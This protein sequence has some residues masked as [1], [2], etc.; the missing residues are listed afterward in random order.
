M[1]IGGGRAVAAHACRQL[2]A[3]PE[4]KGSAAASGVG[5]GPC[6]AG[7]LGREGCIILWSTSPHPAGPAVLQATCPHGVPTL[8]A[9]LP[10]PPTLRAPCSYVPDQSTVRLPTNFK[11]AGSGEAVPLDSNGQ[12]ARSSSTVK[13]KVYCF[14]SR[15]CYFSYRVSGRR[16][17]A[18]EARSGAGA[19][20]AAG[21]RRR[22]GEWPSCHCGTCRSVQRRLGPRLA[23]SLTLQGSGGAT[24]P[25]C[26]P[27]HSPPAR[28]PCRLLQYVDSRKYLHSG[29]ASLKK[30]RRAFLRSV[31]VC[32]DVMC[33]RHGGQAGG[34]G[35]GQERSCSASPGQ[36]LPALAGRL[37]PIRRP[38]STPRL[39]LL[40]P[41]C[42]ATTSTSTRTRWVLGN[43]LGW[44]CVQAVLGAC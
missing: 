7:V 40:H 43:A 41:S 26:T 34:S 23:G 22:A 16:V 32:P 18:A 31:R 4:S 38:D 37:L 5:G 36:G 8:A 39:C 35:G 1:G 25:A 10:S 14:C 17:G 15:G 30:V 11:P 21:A 20:A 42:R 28:T 12:S 13:V 9:Q 6:G 27:W 3:W 24:A 29:T 19:P 2:G 33:S 44:Q